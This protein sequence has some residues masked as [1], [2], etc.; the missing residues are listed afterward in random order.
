MNRHRLVVAA[1]C[2][3]ALAA[4]PSPA[5]ACTT[6]CLRGGDGSVLFGKNYDW[7]IGYGLVV[8]NK[9]GVAKTAMLES[10]DDT[11]AKWVSKYGS[12][13]FNQFGREFPSGGMNEAGLAIE[14][15]WLDE[16]KYPARDARP[17]VGTLGWIEYQLDNYA[18]VQEVLDHADE[19]RVS[20]SVPIHYLVVDKSGAAAS[21]EFLDGKLV[22]HEGATMPAPVLT[23][24]TYDRSVAYARQFRGLGGS[25]VDKSGPAS[26]D[27]FVRAA[28]AVGVYDPVKGSSGVDYAFG[29]L[30]DVA[31]G[32]YTKWSIVYDLGRLRVYFRTRDSSAIKYVD[33][34]AFDLSCATPVTV[35]DVNAPLA[36][37]VSKRFEDYTY[38]RDRA[39]VEASFRGVPFLAKTPAPLLDAVARY[40]ETMGCGR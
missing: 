33:L 24:D 8:T 15:M 13:T 16:T 9:R 40:P 4:L 20:S 37:D 17:A 10:L 12:I 26:L 19:L 31:Q 23:N 5:D 18:T 39:L 3:V 36:G 29:V 28:S 7:N 32:E 35:L 2:L 14:L 34:R 22:C 25:R 21:V 1:A 38:E 11:P 6:F 27:R 30:A